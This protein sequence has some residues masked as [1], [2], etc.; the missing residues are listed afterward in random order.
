[1]KRWMAS[2]WFSAHLEKESALRT[3]RLTRW[4]KVQK[5]AFDVAGL[6]GFFA[7]GAV[8]AFGERRGVGIPVVAAGGAP[9]VAQ[10]QVRPQVARALQAAI[11][12]RPG[13][14][15]AGATAKR[16][17]QPKRLC[18]AAH[19]APK[20]IEFEHVAL[21]ARQQRVHEGR[22]TFRFFP[23]SHFMTVW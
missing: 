9:T 14:D 16:H 5:P 23:P 12:Q 15:L 21:F 10:R 2:R 3:N 7:A 17:P 6:A 11:S 19:E 20:F 4:R 13:H 18:F 1:M 22:Q 8:G